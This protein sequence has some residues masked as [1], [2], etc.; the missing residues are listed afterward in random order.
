MK[1]RR[2][3]KRRMRGKWEG[4]KMNEMMRGTRGMGRRR[5]REERG[6]PQMIAALEAVAPNL[7]FN[8]TACVKASTQ[9][10]RDIPELKDQEDNAITEWAELQGKMIR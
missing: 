1:E 3:R 7:S 10:A 4:G 8:S 9:L 5:A 2:T 6:P